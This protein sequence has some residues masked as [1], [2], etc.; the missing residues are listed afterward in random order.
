M[1]RV[2]DHL[3][4]SGMPTCS[5]AEKIAD[6][7][8]SFP[9]HVSSILTVELSMENMDFKVDYTAQ[10]FIFEAFKKMSTFL[11]RKN[12]KHNSILYSA[13]MTPVHIGA[14]TVCLITELV[15]KPL[16]LIG[17]YL[18]NKALEMDPDAKTYN[19]LAADHIQLLLEQEATLH[20][21]ETLKKELE[22][23]LIDE[24]IYNLALEMTKNYPVGFIKAILALDSISIVLILKPILRDDVIEDYEITTTSSILTRLPTT[25]NTLG[26][27]IHSQKE[28][29]Q[30]RESQ[31]VRKLTQF[32]MASQTF[33]NAIQELIK[34]NL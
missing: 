33:Q 8:L 6:S 15:S 28:I 5:L 25:R 21:I 7:C 14:S 19:R 22:P 18:K 17:K 2:G 4:I 3:Y 10:G 9:R 16:E 26:H 34:P 24:Q 13:S 27:H 12:D 1:H 30:D 20:G 32:G 11:A 23:L 31:L 29:I